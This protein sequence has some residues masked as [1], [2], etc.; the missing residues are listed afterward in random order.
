MQTKPYIEQPDSDD[1]PD[2][3]LADIWWENHLKRDISAIQSIFTGQ[4][5]SI[6]TCKH[7]EY[8]SARYEPFNMLSVPLPEEAFRSLV[9]YVFTLTS[10][11]LT[12]S[13]RISKA[14]VLKDVVEILKSYQIDGVKEDS[15]F[16]PVQMSNFRV[17]NFLT[18]LKP[19]DTIR[20]SDFLVFYQVREIPVTR[21]LPT[22]VQAKDV[23]EKQMPPLVGAT[24][25]YGRVIPPLRT[26]ASQSTS[27]MEPKESSSTPFPSQSEQS[28]GQS[29]ME[30]EVSYDGDSDSGEELGKGDE[31]EKREVGP[32]QQIPL[33]E[34]FL[35]DVEGEITGD[36]PSLGNDKNCQD[37]VSLFSFLPPFLAPSFLTD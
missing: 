12:C 9:L 15:L 14:G 3:V 36:S 28:L 35:P 26:P 1:R 34:D 11:F 16:I 8:N 27:P 13:V 6:T 7:C 22:V 33:G 31:D 17:V 18:L 2:Q 19:I 29:E 30:R 32:I 5:K 10:Q 21:S 20:D 23:H 37:T 4:F 24:G 25:R